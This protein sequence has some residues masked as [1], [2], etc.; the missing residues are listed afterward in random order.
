MTV[1]VSD[2]MPTLA[3]PD[4]AEAAVAESDEPEALRAR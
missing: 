2:W 3:R 1:E 4:D